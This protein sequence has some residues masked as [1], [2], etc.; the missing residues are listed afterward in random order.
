VEESD[1]ATSRK[2]N[3][4]CVKYDSLQMTCSSQSQ[5]ADRPASPLCASFDQVD[6]SMFVTIRECVSPAMT[7]ILIA[8]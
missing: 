6:S 3:R 8:L 5:A 1:R 7:S 2:N 4:H